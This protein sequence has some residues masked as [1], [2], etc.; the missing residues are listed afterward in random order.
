MICLSWL[1]WEMPPASLWNRYSVI[2][3]GRSGRR[4]WKNGESRR[5]NPMEN[6]KKQLQKRRKYLMMNLTR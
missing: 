4:K 2:L 6:Q 1:S 5:K 3:D